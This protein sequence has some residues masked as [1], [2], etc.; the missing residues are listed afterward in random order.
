MPTR[1]TRT[2]C[3]VARSELTELRSSGRYIRS[4]IPAATTLKI[5]IT[6]TSVDGSVKMEPKS[7]LI[8]APVVLDAVVSR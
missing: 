4:T 5:A 6:G 7:T 3:A 2:P 8:V 1:R